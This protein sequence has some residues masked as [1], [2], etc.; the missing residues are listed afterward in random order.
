LP[1]T[2]KTWTNDLTVDEVIAHFQDKP[3]RFEPGSKYECSNSGYV[4]FVRVV[5]KASGQPFEEFLPKT[6]F[7]PLGMKDTGIDNP[8]AILPH[9]AT[10][11]YQEENGVIQ[12]PYLYVPFTTGAGNIRTFGQPFSISVRIS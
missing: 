9:R 1:D 4:L 2:Y 12:A 6:I 10:G 7:D 3:L 5:E 8:L 11:H